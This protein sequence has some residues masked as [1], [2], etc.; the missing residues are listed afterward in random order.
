MPPEPTL[1]L[2]LLPP[3]QHETEIS[4]QAA[5]LPQWLQVLHCQGLIRLLFGIK[6][7]LVELTHVLLLLVLANLQQTTHRRMMPHLVTA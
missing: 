4:R 2:T 3:T 7:P 6:T 5:C 1:K